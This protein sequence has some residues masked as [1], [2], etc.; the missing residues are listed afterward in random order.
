MSEIDEL[1]KEVRALRKLVH[2]RE[3]THPASAVT[4]AAP[5]N[6][7]YLVGTANAGLS[8]EIPVGTTPGGELGGTWASPTVDASH[9]GSAHHTRLHTVTDTSDHTFPG[10][11]TTFLRADG[12]FA[13][14]GGGV[15]GGVYGPLEVVG[16]YYGILNFGGAWATG[17]AV[18]QN[19]DAWPVVFGRTATY[20]RIGVSVTANQTANWNLRLGLYS[21]N[22]SYY[23][24]SLVFDA[25]TVDC[26]A[27]ALRTITISQQV[28]AG[29]YWMVVHTIMAS[30][31]GAPS[32]QGFGGGA[33]LAAPFLGYRDNG[34]VFGQ[35]YGGA[36]RRT[37]I[38]A[39]SLASTFA[40]GAN[41]TTGISPVPIMRV[42][43]LP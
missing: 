1:R 40:A 4:G 20:D 32:L 6:A 7:D 26:S 24:G 10:G 39:A 30:A 16:R 25:G 37:G 12:T 43:S 21:D 13:T 14:A 15:S 31:A 11:T 22:G 18:D 19:L 28:T 34:A 36:Y 38:A 35:N 23:P 33:A 9:S 2:S 29:L 41:I 17:A 5:P 42:A 3:H 8:A 27:A